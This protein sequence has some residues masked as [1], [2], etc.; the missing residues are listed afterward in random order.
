MASKKLADFLLDLGRHPEKLKALKAAPDKFMKDAGLSDEDIEIVKSGDPAKLRA[1][2]DDA[3]LTG[4]TNVVVV[5]VVV[6]A[7]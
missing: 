6:I 3:A 4:D 5:A 7:A 1:A 2:I